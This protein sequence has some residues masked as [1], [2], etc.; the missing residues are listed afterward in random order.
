MEVI[1]F[2]YSD[3]E[4]R[5]PMELHRQ[6]WRNLKEMEIDVGIKASE[7]DVLAWPPSE[8]SYRHAPEFSF[9]Y[10]IEDDL[11][12]V[13]VIGLGDHFEYRPGVPDGVVGVGLTVAETQRMLADPARPTGGILDLVKTIYTVL[14][15]PPAFGYGLDPSH[16]EDPTRELPVTT[17]SIDST[18]LREVSWLMLFPPS[19]VDVYGREMLLDAP[20][21]R[22]E[23]LDDGAILL[24]ATEN[25]VETSYEDYVALHDY[26]G[27]EQ[28]M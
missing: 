10:Y 27:I 12:G 4:S 25:P 28:P 17:G 19:Y 7:P 20:V 21:W 5:N 9:T 11:V 3:D 22:A 24:V 1:H 15:D 16:L 18:R 13:S 14:E 6:V 2:I 23:E 8:G 26:F